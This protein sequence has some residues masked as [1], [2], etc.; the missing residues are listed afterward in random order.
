MLSF[1]TLYAQQGSSIRSFGNFKSHQLYSD[2]V[3]AINCSPSFTAVAELQTEGAEVLGMAPGSE[4]REIANALAE[5]SRL[6]CNL[7]ASG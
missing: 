5:R 6:P 2:G 3:Y 4:E 7:P 1:E